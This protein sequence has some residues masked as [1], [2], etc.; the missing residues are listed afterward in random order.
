MKILII[1]LVCSAFTA[2]I[3]TDLF[4]SSRTANTNVS[5]KLTESNLPR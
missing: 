2:F 4:P 3:F 1:A 5:G